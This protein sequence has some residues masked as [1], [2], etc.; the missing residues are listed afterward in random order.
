[1]R[2][3]AVV[4]VTG[5]AQAAQV[6]LRYAPPNQI[7]DF[8][9]PG[10]MARMR[11]HR[12]PTSSFSRTAPSSSLSAQCGAKLRDLAQC[13]RE[14]RRN[15]DYLGMLRNVRNLDAIHWAFLVASAK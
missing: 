6:S 15:S 9:F 1:M 14:C 3:T 13:Q 7:P 4:G 8:Q 12:E 5:N 2:L 10:L 11:L